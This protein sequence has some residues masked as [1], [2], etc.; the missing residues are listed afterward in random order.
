[1]LVGAIVPTKNEDSREIDALYGVLYEFCDRILVVDRGTLAEAYA[2]AEDQFPA[3][4]WTVHVDVGHDPKDVRDLI[5]VADISRVDVTI[6]SRF[7]P[8][9]EFR[10]PLSRKARSKT[11]AAM[12]NLISQRQIADWTSGMRVYSPKARALLAEHEFRT[13]GHAWQ[14][15]S[16]WVCLKAGLTYTEAPI[17]YTAGHSHMNAG[18]A[19]EAAKLW[20]HLATSS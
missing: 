15:E 18:R 17:T 7:C 12:M 9:A 8:G 2:I 14:I 19:W 16:L 1:M 10:G 11:M 4:F 13:Q 5:D 20:G 3:H 6:G